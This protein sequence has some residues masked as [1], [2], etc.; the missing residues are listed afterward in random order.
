M[1]FDL[2]DMTLTSDSCGHY[3][4]QG[5][6]TTLVSL[7]LSLF[8]QAATARIHSNDEGQNVNKPT[9]TDFRSTHT[10]NDDD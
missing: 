1:T 4:D 2:A 6:D 3:C 8:S 7:C 9:Q 10:S 5:S